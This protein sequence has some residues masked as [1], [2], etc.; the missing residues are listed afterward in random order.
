MF[1]IC[2]YVN[3]FNHSSVESTT[4]W[5]MLLVVIICWSMLIYCWD[6]ADSASLFIPTIYVKH[7]S[8]T[9]SCDRYDFKYDF[10]TYKWPSWLNPQSKQL[11]TESI[12][13]GFQL[14]AYSIIVHPIP[15]PSLACLLYGCSWEN[16]R[17]HYNIYIYTYCGKPN[18]NCLYFKHIQCRNRVYLKISERIEQLFLSNDYL[19]GICFFLRISNPMGRNEKDPLHSAFFLRRCVAW[20]HQDRTPNVF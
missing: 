17:K 6:I 20:G 3:V 18:D 1:I 7:Q 11:R 19:I 10:V 9:Y 8:S 14:F 15:I 12:K 2:T 5:Y 16:M 4:C 13:W